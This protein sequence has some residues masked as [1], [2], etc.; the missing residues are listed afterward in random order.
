L[1]DAELVP[2]HGGTI[3][4]YAGRRGT[5]DATG[6]L[7]QL[8]RAEAAS[9]VNTLA[10]Y[11]VFASRITAR[12]TETLLYLDGLKAQGKRVFGFG[13]PVKGNTLLN[14][15]GIGPDRIECLVEKNELRRGL[16]APGS[17][18]PVLIERELPAPP[19]VY[20]VLAWNFK[21]EILANN[22]AL[23]E[24]GV[25]FHFPVDPPVAA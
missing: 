7:E 5:R 2:I 19:D 15:F 9:A 3:V 16:F 21:R 12:K 13:A 10:S 1:F 22:R 25:Q 6:R 24:R 4:G 18:I 23:L 17:H 14:T 11:R 20:F 8:R